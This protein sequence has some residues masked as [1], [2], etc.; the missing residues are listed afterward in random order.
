MKLRNALY[1]NNNLV[2]S[3]FYSLK[4]GTAIPSNQI[5]IRLILEYFFNKLQAKNQS[6]NY[7]IG[8]Q[9]T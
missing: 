5:I 8:I 6:K 3:P 7:F 4:I 2:G 1:A 9:Q